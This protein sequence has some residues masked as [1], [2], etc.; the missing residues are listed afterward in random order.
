MLKEVFTYRCMEDGVVKDVTTWVNFN[1][2][3]HVEVS[4]H[5]IWDVVEEEYIPVPCIDI[6]YN[7]KCVHILDMTLEQV[8][9]IINCAP[10]NHPYRRSL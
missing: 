6:Y 2:V 4:T 9:D 1:L 5:G 7:N 3:T 10:K 8:L